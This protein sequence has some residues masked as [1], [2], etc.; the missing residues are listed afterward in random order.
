METIGL[1]TPVTRFIGVFVAT[2]ALVY[3]IKPSYF[4]EQITKEPSPNAI[5]PWWTIGLATGA[6][7]AFFL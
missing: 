3:F 4:F 5:A 6:I 7:A 2:N 1:R